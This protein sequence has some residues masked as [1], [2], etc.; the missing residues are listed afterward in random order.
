MSKVL[1]ICAVGLLLC[2][3][4]LPTAAMDADLRDQHISLAQSDLKQGRWDKSLARFRWLLLESNPDPQFAI[5]YQNTIA[6]ITNE[7]P[8]SFGLN[9]ALLPSTNVSKASSHS[10]FSTL[11]GD[12]T[13]DSAEDRQSGIGLHFGAS[14]TYSH[15]YERGRTLFISTGLS[16]NLYEQK[17]LQVAQGGVT[18]GH[19]WLSAGRQIRLTLARNSYRYHDIDDRDAPDFKSSKLS[20]DSYHRLNARWSLR[21]HASLQD[22]EYKER[23]YNSGRHKNISFT[24]KFQLNAQNA[25]SLKLGYQD[26]NIEAPHLSFEGRSLGVFWDR[27]ERNG[28]RW[29]LGAERVWRAYDSQ[30]PTLSVNRSDRVTDLIL[31][32]SHPKLKIRDMTPKLR[33]TYRNHGSNVALYDYKSTDCSVTF[34]YQF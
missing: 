28:M 1:V 17:E 24:P 31:S 22:S 23:P 10:V 12:F 19:E 3:F 26:V 6:S 20:F 25:L 14:A 29:G 4:A 7:N 33:C 5:A 32:A 27:V 2:A 11:L 21:A 15:V 30:F 9:F 13:I 8:L 34:S 16:T 18:L